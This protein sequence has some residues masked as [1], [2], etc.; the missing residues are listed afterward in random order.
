[1]RTSQTQNRAW[2]QARSLSHLASTVHRDPPSRL[3]WRNRFVDCP[4][5]S[6]PAGEPGPWKGSVHR[7][8]AH[9]LLCLRPYHSGGVW[10][11]LAKPLALEA[12][13]LKM[14]SAL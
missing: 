12:T 1:M 2:R 6:R 14:F 8:P 13:L 10:S 5:S 3:L 4:H 9:P 7:A 11:H